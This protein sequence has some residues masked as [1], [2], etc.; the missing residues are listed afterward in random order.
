MS[1][2][3]CI[4]GRCFSG[5]I[6]ITFPMLSD[7]MTS[8]CSLTAF[9]P[10]RKKLYIGKRNSTDRIKGR[11]RVQCLAGNLVISSQKGS[12]TLPRDGKGAQIEQKAGKFLKSHCGND[13]DEERMSNHPRTNDLIAPCYQL[14]KIPR[15]VIFDR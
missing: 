10:N 9:K 2:E 8:T 3:L 13:D 5:T 6:R 12:H 1:E 15:E 11:D 14:N 7:G 4:M